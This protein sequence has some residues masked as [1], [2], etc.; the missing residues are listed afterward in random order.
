MSGSK[1][2][3][4]GKLAQTKQGQ[5]EGGEPRIFFKKKTSRSSYRSPSAA[6]GPTCESVWQR[7]FVYE[8]GRGRESPLGEVGRSERFFCHREFVHAC[9]SYTSA[10]PCTELACGPVLVSPS[11]SAERQRYLDVITREF[12]V[13][14]RHTCTG[15]PQVANPRAPVELLSIGTHQEGEAVAT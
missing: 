4:C 6:A 15:Q 8:E 10:I 11:L 12:D 9:A 14:T 7:E 2:H 5:E 1:P 3:T 13:V